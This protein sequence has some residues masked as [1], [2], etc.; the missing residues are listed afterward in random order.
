MHLWSLLLLLGLPPCA[1]LLP[2]PLSRRAAIAAAAT[3]ALPGVLLLPLAASARFVGAAAQL[4]PAAVTG[5]A[6]GLTGGGGL[7]MRFEQGQQEE[8]G[9]RKKFLAQSGAV[10]EAPKPY[11]MVDSSLKEVRARSC[12]HYD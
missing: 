11:V 6:R 12:L 4:V 1:A 9:D 5:S 8:E 2:A 10:A 7:G 3:A